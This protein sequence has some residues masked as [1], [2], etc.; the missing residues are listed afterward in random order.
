MFIENE[1][2]EVF[3]FEELPTYETK[4]YISGDPSSIKRICSRE[5]MIHELCVSVTETDFVYNGGKEIGAVIGILNYPRFP[6]EITWLDTFAVNLARILVK[7]THQ[8][9]ATVVNS[10]KTTWI[11][12]KSSYN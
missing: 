8:K 6:K 1:D 12:R 5:A 4:I 9:S 2:Y 10:T 7:E 3:G 11:Y